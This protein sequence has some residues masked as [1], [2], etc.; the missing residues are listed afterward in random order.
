MFIWRTRLVQPLG[1]WTLFNTLGAI[2]LPIITFWD[3][4]LGVFISSL[5]DCYSS[6]H[7]GA[8]FITPLVGE[9][10]CFVGIG[11]VCYPCERFMLNW[12][13]CTCPSYNSPHSTLSCRLG[14][15]LVFRELIRLGCINGCLC[16]W[17]FRFSISIWL[18]FPSLPSA[19]SNTVLAY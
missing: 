14:L 18:P 12:S 17:G 11:K 13:V 9:L 7:K 6:M 1:V 4:S 3:S 8:T 5:A 15:Q 10:T 16:S 19:W 2:I